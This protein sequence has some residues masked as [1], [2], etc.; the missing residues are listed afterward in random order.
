VVGRAAQR[1]AIMNYGIT[2]VGIY[3]AKAGNRGSF[4][5]NRGAVFIGGGVKK[6]ELKPSIA[7]LCKERRTLSTMSRR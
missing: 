5:K 4:G 1:L 6:I 3:G 7:I 2:A